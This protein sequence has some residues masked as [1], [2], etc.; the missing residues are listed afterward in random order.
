MALAAFRPVVRLR[1]YSAVRDHH[2]RANR[3]AVAINRLT[4]QRIH[5]GPRPSGFRYGRTRHMGQIR[6]W[7]SIGVDG[8]SSPDSFRAGQMRVTVESGT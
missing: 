8:S 4:Q 1:D 6:P 2:D 7:C 3:L 5:H